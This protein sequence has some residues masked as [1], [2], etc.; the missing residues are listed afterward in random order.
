MKPLRLSG[1]YQKD[2][3]LM[4]RRG[5][6]IK[7]LIAVVDQLRAGQQLP[8]QNVDHPL[9]GPWHTYRGCHIQGD[10]V[11]IYKNLE[12]ELLLARTGTHSDLFNE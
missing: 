7:K 2:L 6:R 5:Y 1:Q 10:W 4:E 9:R 8:R 12:T 3:R 11:L